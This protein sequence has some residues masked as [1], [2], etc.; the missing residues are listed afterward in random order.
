MIGWVDNHLIFAFWSLFL[1]CLILLNWKKK[2]GE[3]FCKK[4][5][6]DTQK[7]RQGCMS[8]TEKDPTIQ[9]NFILLIT[10][11]T[12]HNYNITGS[13]VVVG[14]TWVIMLPAS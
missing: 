4:I 3:M 13:V 7:L 5:L 8:K 11:S 1:F 12:V 14:N 6:G 2:T 10:V 9:F